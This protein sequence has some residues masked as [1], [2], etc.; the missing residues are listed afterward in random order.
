[1]LSPLRKAPHDYKSP[2]PGVGAFL[3]Y[4]KL[5]KLDPGSSWKEFDR[6][7]WVVVP[8]LSALWERAR[9]PRLARDIDRLHYIRETLAVAARFG[10]LI[11][12]D[13]IAR[14]HKHGPLDRYLEKK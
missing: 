8:G 12:L 2:T 9:H 7:P 13:E 14:K 5:K 6:F 11:S 10:V 1:I 4:C 3:H